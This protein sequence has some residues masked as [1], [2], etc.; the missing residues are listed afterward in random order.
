LFVVVLV[1][2]ACESIDQKV[3]QHPIDMKI[4]VHVTKDISLIG[5]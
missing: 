5:L 1:N 4:S 3:K 2:I